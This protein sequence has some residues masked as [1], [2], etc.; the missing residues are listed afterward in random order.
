MGRSPTG[1]F[2]GCLARGGQERA[3]Q[4]DFQAAIAQEIEAL[5]GRRVVQGLDFEPHTS[6]RGRGGQMIRRFCV[7]SMHRCVYARCGFYGQRAESKPE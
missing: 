6:S 1:G 5:L 4:A 7:A 2:R 3:I